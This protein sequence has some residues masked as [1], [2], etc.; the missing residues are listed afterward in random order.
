VGPP[1]GNAVPASSTQTIKVNATFTALSCTATAG[2]LGSAGAA[3]NIVLDVGDNQRYFAVA[4]AEALIGIDINGNG[5]AE[6]NANF[7]SRV[8]Q[9]DTS[10]LGNTRFYYGLMG[11]APA[12]PRVG[13]HVGEQQSRQPGGACAQ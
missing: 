7:N 5:V 2:T 3:T 1:C 8:D 12:E 4:L 13:R 6:I 9:N 10:C 11:P